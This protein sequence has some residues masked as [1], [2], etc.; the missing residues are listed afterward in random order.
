MGGL[1]VVLLGLLVVAMGIGIARRQSRA[2]TNKL[3]IIAQQLGYRFD[4]AAGRVDII[5]DHKS[6]GLLRNSGGR[7]LNRMFA[8]TNNDSM[9]FD[10]RFT[11]HSGRHSHWVY[12]TVVYFSSVTPLPNFVMRPGNF[13]HKIAVHLVIGTSTFP[14]MPVFPAAT[15]LE[16]KMRKLSETSLR[17]AC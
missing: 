11:H 8:H 13:F 16:V 10:Y 17:P 12:Q 7:I 9:M 14:V 2:R 3:E 1:I 6:F 5:P 15:S 4:R